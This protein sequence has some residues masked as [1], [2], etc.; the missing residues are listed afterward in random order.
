MPRVYLDLRAHRESHAAGQTPF[1]PAIAVVY[2]V[3]E[4]LRLMTAEGAEPIFA[5]HE[6]CAAASR[7]GL[8]RSASSC[9][10]TRAHASQDRHRARVVPDD[11]DWKAFNTRAQAPR[12]RAGRRPGQ[13]DR[14]DLPARPPRLGH[15]RGDP[16]RDE[17]PR[18]RRRSRRAARSGRAPR[19]PPPRSRRSSRTGSC[20][21]RRRGGCVRVLVAEPV[22]RKGS[23]SFVPTTKSTNGTGCR[24]TSCAR[25]SPTTTP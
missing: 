4:G 7:A 1:T 8:R 6:A 14:Q 17:R 24:A 9:S 22:A 20:A 18:D 25:S 11:L 15:A 2:Q 19:S 23:I 12:P 5:R 16:R 21:D 13:A 10:P 3:D